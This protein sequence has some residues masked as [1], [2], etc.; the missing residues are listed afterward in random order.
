V[1]DVDVVAEAH[2]PLDEVGELPLG[3]AAHQAVDAVKDAHP[4]GRWAPTGAR[5]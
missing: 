3:A 4:S 1:D 5:A 2:Q